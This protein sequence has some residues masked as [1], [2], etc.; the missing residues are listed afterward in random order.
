V[1]QSRNYL[2]H[3][4]LYSLTNGLMQVGGLVMLTL[5]THLL[6]P[7]EYGAFALLSNLAETVSMILLV[8]G[9]RQ[10]FLTFYQQGE[11]D[12]DRQRVLT[13]T[14][15]FFALAG[16]VGG[17]VLCALA[18]PTCWL[19]GI[20]EPGGLLSGPSLLR[21]AIISV[22]IDPF[23][24][25]PLVLFQVRLESRGYFLVSVIRLALRILVCTTLMLALGLGVGGALLG[26]ALVNGTFALVM[27]W[28]ELRRG[29]A[30]PDRAQVGEMVR[31]ALPF[32]PA[33]LCFFVLHDGNRF[34]LAPW[35]TE[36]VGLYHLG[37]KLAQL[38]APFTLL[39]LIAVWNNRMYDVAKTP[40]APVVFG[41]VFT[42]ILAVYLFVGLGLLLF[43]DEIL[44]TLAHESYA[45]AAYFTPLVL[46][47]CGFQAMASLMDAGFYVR[48]RT[49]L[50]LA[51]TLA[52][53]AVMLTG[54]AT[55]IP[56]LG[57]LGAVLAG[58]AGFA[59]LAGVTWLVTRRLFP[60]NYEPG[61]LLA[62]VGLLILAWGLG[63]LLPVGW[64]TAPLKVLAWLAVPG[65][66]W[67]LGLISP[68]EKE[69]LRTIARKLMARFSATRVAVSRSAANHGRTA[70]QDALAG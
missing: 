15:A 8:G 11:N 44:A 17:L 56:R 62:F 54:Y 53:T 16:L 64:G 65:L 66:A 13:G 55:L 60:V 23:C 32:L 67:G 41:R 1:S 47:A 12:L 9:F 31:F 51:V 40:E 10:A 35:G 34:F 43:V 58:I 28:R 50:K 33:S 69:Y 27:G 5:Y 22:L 52:A 7:K 70:A 36:Q 14:Y 48:R 29:I 61:R 24:I 25:V 59:F 26:T 37:Y 38:V 20:D 18:G 57:A 6:T 21:L 30:W 49:D 46:I 4:A 3:A 39:P 68:D 45:G 42:W 19:L 2:G 63:R